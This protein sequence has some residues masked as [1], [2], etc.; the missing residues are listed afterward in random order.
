M[1]IG[2]RATAVMSL[3]CCIVLGGCANHRLE[4]EF[5]F[6]NPAATRMARSCAPIRWTIS[7]DTFTGMTDEIRFSGLANP[8]QRGDRYAR[9]P[10]C[11][12]SSIRVLTT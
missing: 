7:I 2:G 1:S 9:L 4:K 10:F 3:A 8:L 12:R 5:F 11:W 6:K